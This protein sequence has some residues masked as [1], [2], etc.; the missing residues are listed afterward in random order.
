MERKTNRSGTISRAPW[1]AEA[2]QVPAQF[3]Q[4][5]DLMKPCLKIKTKRAEDIS[6]CESPGF[7]P[8]YRSGVHITYTVFLLH[9][10]YRQMFRYAA[11]GVGNQQKVEI[12][13]TAIGM[14]RQW[15]HCSYGLTILI[16]PE[17]FLSSLLR[18]SDIKQF[19]HL[20][21]TIKIFSVVMKLYNHRYSQKEIWYPLTFP[22][23][24]P[25]ETINLL[26]S[27]QVA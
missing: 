24:F 3:E 16:G 21:C 8:Q 25:P 22:S 13:S 19:S 10:W 11:L 27:I 15:H 20:K 9:H 18:H 17:T 12:A 6:Q 23:P 5:G 2:G 26:S 14:C 4:L 7:H 1:E